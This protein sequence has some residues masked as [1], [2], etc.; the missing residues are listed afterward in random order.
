MKAVIRE[1]PRLKK[2]YDALHTVSITPNYTNSGGKGYAISDP[3][4]QAAIREL[5]EQNQREYE[6]VKCAIF[7]TEKKSAGNLRLDV[8]RKV[9]WQR[10]HTL[11]GAADAIHIS[12]R[13][14]RRYQI[15]F[16][17]LTAYFLGLF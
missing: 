10:S 4:A 2:E 17:Y 13:T 16:V 1:Y 14:A 5:Q 7:V 8:I 3:T 11:Q 6:A 15:D 12:Y 9:F